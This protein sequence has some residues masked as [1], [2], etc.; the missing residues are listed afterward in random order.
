M[1]NLYQGPW[2]NALVPKL[3]L[4]WSPLVELPT[5][6]PQVSTF[7]A[8]ASNCKKI[9]PTKLFSLNR[10]SWINLVR[11]S[12]LFDKENITYEINLLCCNLTY[13]SFEAPRG[14]RPSFLEPMVK[15]LALLQFLRWSRLHS[16]N[17]TII[18]SCRCKPVSFW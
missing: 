16:Q 14:I 13:N 5:S 12:P 4:Q 17:K 6:H 15:W 9:V 1:Q 3:L 10:E 11:F 18:S 2:C 8:D 7:T